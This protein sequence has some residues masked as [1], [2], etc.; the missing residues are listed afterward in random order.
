MRT[1]SSSR[2]PKNVRAPGR[3]GGGGGEGG[4]GGGEGGGAGAVCDVQPVGEQHVFDHTN[5]WSCPHPD[6]QHTWLTSSACSHNRLPRPAHS[7]RAAAN[8]PTSKMY[9]CFGL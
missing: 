7:V 5:R 6:P 3:S 1:V 9:A 4:G 2:S 8:V